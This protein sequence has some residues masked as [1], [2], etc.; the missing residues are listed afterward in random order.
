MN[1]PFN[2]PL[3]AW[4]RWL[5]FGALGGFV[6]LS[7]LS[8]FV[9]RD[10]IFQ[11]FLDPGVPF[12]TYQRPPAPDYTQD[13]AW[14]AR[15]DVRLPD[16]AGHPAVFFIHPTTYDG[17]SH[18]NAP[19]DRPQEAV[20]LSQIV[21][22]N[23]AAPFLVQDVELYAPRY[24]QASLYTFMNNREDSVLARELAQMDI[25]RAFTQFL[26]E[27]DPEQ[28]FFIVGVGQG[29]AIALDVLARR[30]A[31]DPAVRR[32]LT[33]AYIIEAPTPL[34]LLAGPLSTIPVCTD[35][36]EV[37]CLVGWV[38]VRPQETARI[39]ALTQRSRAL[40]SR[41][42]LTPVEDRA[43]LCVNPVLWTANE[44]YAPARLHRGAAAAEGLMLTDAPSPMTNQ[45]GAQCQGGLLMIDQPRAS[46]L[47]RPGRLAEDRRVRPSNLFYMDIRANAQAR[48]EVM[49]AIMADE[50]RYAPPLDAP[51]EVEVAPITPIDG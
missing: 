7:A 35:P 48:L 5:L 3:T 39:E 20:E 10:Q 13:E 15:P 6:L 29:G 50:A 31:P 21:L 30:V 47:R 12:Q 17:G 51:L 44:D 19:Y 28:P 42:R 26:R 36:S 38:A 11:T 14:A 45:T 2:I 37:R 49:R 33:A 46:A 27:T 41:G 32:R 8:A 4:L 23:Y 25:Q 34:D 9:L 24:R 43:L 16:E 40:D 18:W 1:G 22:P